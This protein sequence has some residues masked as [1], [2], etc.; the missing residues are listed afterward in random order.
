MKLKSYRFNHELFLQDNSKLVV[1]NFKTWL[2]FETK[3]ELGLAFEVI[4]L[5]DDSEN[6]FETFNVKIRNWTLEK[7]NLKIGDYIQIFDIE[8]A[9]IFGQYQNEVSFI[10]KIKKVEVSGHE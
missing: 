3:K 4:I 5:N 10:A 9:S 8:K 2:D 7:N 6:Y 1:K